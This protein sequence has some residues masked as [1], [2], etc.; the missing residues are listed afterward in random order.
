[1]DCW[2]VVPDTI[3]D[4][5]L[6][7]QLLPRRYATEY[8]VYGKV[9]YWR[10]EDMVDHTVKVAVPIFNAAFPGYQAVFLFDS[11]S[12]HSSHAADALRVGNMNLHPGGKQAITTV[13][14]QENQKE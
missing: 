3:S 7:G 5:E 9:K 4:A 11:A 10:G 1:M 8:F 14:W 12:N 6:A 13:S 2:L